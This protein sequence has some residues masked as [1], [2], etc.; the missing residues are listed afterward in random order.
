MINPHSSIPFAADAND[1][2]PFL[3]HLCLHSSSVAITHTLPRQR[4]PFSAAAIADGSGLCWVGYHNGDLTVLN[5]LAW[6]SWE[7]RLEE[8]SRPSGSWHGHQ[9]FSRNY[10]HCG[11]VTNLFPLLGKD[12]IAIFSRGSILRLR[13]LDASK[14]V[15]I[16]EYKGHVNEGTT[17]IV[18]TLHPPS[19]LLA[20]RGTDKTLRIWHLADEYPLNSLWHS[21]RLSTRQLN[22]EISSPNL[23]E[24]L[25]G[26]SKESA[27]QHPFRRSK[28]FMSLVHENMNSVATQV[29]MSVPLASQEIDASTI[30]FVP[31][32]WAADRDAV[33]ELSR[34]FDEVGCSRLIGAGLFPGLAIACNHDST[35]RILYYQPR[36]TTIRKPELRRR[37]T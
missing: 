16:M 34:D 20:V 32:S 21:P 22:I 14:L 24:R 8:G 26:R 29:G 1:R 13:F 23:H 36:R 15:Q 25:L 18:A 33:W 19:Q 5:T 28:A 4:E 30:A 11:A 9:A 7:T 12:V 37:S 3:R 35:L 27:A 10:R 31:T 2:G 17:Q 6:L